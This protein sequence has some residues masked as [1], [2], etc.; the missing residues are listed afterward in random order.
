[1]ASKRREHRQNMFMKAADPAWRKLIVLG[2]VYGALWSLVAA[3]MLV[4]MH[5]PITSALKALGYYT[6]AGILT[7][8]AVTFLLRRRLATA[9]TA[10]T[11]WS[12]PL[13]LLL[14][15]LGFAFFLGLLCLAA[16]VF[17]GRTPN[18]HDSLV[19]FYWCP[20]V[21]FG[22][23]FPI[24]LAALNCW[25]LRRRLATLAPA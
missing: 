21:A 14:G 25:D 17:A 9:S 16:D 4:L 19:L 20:F 11:L 23:L 13:A 3:L 24:G 7:G 22:A 6:P 10:K 15:T 8:I 12:G 5:E 18:L 2:A 1:M